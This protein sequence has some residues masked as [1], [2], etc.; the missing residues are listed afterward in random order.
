M[1]TR[2]AFAPDRSRFT[3]QAF[4]T[5]M[6]SFLGHSPT[7]AVRDFSGS[8]KFDPDN[9]E[10]AALDLTIAPD[11]LSLLDPVSAADRAEIEGRMRRDVL[12]TSVFPEIAFQADDVAARPA[13]S[14]RY[15]LE[16]GGRLSLH[17]VA[18]P[19]WVEA[20]LLLSDGGVH[21]RGEEQLSMP[22]FRIKPVSAVGGTIKL[23]DQ[24]MLSFDLFGLPEA[25]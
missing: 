22:D 11:S 19:Y 18:Q 24:A 10:A 7:F 14:G 12:E 16:L 15:R 4:A 1:M 6:L 25:S 9:L 17:G 20:E 21:L 8:L 3:M 13:G 23:K 5:G 2:Y